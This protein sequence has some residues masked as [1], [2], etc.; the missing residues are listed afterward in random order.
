[1]ME[2]KSRLHERERQLEDLVN[3][4]EAYTKTGA[5]SWEVKTQLSLTLIE[6]ISNS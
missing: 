5:P 2:I 4:L 3:D 6:G 1:M